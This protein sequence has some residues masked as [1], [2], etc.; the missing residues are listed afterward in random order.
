MESDNLLT[1]TEVRVLGSL[2]EKKLATPEYYP[3]S[4]VSLIAACNQKTNR[5]PV[6]SLSEETVLQGVKSLTEKKMARVSR[7]SRVLKYEEQFDDER[8]F[9]RREAAVI[10]IL[11]LRGAQTAGEIKGRT[12]R[13]HQFEQLEDVGHTLENLIAD[14]LV[15]RMSLQPGQKEVRYHHLLCG[16]PETAAKTDILSLPI[17]TIS[18]Y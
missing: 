10:C 12:N 2:L 16:P 14:D 17:T 4:M 9:T 15:V 7:V 13:L 1:S 8:K 6:V 18:E 5:N 11:M 3:L